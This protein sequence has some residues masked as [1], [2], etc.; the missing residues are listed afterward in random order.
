MINPRSDEHNYVV[1]AGLRS[2][3]RAQLTGVSAPFQY[4]IQPSYGR[5]GAITI[6]RGR[7]LAK[8]TLTLWLW[9]PEH[10]VGWTAFQKVL[11]PPTPFKPLV[12]EMRHPLLTEAGIKAVAVEEL[13][14]PQRQDNGIWVVTIK[15]LEYRP[16]KPVLVKPRGAIPSPDKGVPVAPKTEADRALVQAK[17]DFEAARSAARQ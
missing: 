15:L 14:Q 6:F 2:P 4:D 1:V 9:L 7:G 5:E 11:Q 8:P 12:V 13:G 10:F 3:G 16:P 17:A